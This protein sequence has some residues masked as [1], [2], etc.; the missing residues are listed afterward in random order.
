[1]RTRPAREEDLADIVAIYNSTVPLRQVTADVEPVTVESRREWLRGHVG[2]EPL[3]VLDD[4]AVAG[5]VAF[6]QFRPRAGYRPTAE[7]S[8]YI[9]ADRRGRGLGTK[10]LAE[11]IDAAPALGYRRLCG[12]VLDNNAASLRLTARA[13]FTEW[14]RMPGVVELDGIERDVVIVGRSS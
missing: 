5:W 13:G 4:G 8:L 12:L 3:W 6:T 7:L 2:D 1:M 9:A 14:G 10:L 11:A